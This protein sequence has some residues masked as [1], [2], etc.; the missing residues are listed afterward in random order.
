MGAVVGKGRFGNVHKAHDQETGESVALKF[1]ERHSKSRE[2][3]ERER[4]AF[5]LLPRHHPHI[6]QLRGVEEDVD[7]HGV[8]NT[9]FVLQLAKREDML[10][11]LLKNKGPLSENQSRTYFVQLL[12]ALKAAHARRLFHMDVKL[13][14][15]LLDDNKDILLCDWGLSLHL[16]EAVSSPSSDATSPS[17]SSS[18][19]PS[20]RCTSSDAH[21]DLRIGTEGYM[22]P[23]MFKNETY[24]PSKAD[25]WSAV[26]VV[27]AMYVGR[28]PFVKA[29]ESDWHFKRISIGSQSKFW[30]SHLSHSPWVSEAFQK[31][32]N[33]VFTPSGSTRA[34][35]DDI[36]NDPW[37]LASEAEPALAPAPAA[38]AD[39][40]R[41]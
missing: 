4:A 40:K 30:G 28:P 32:V 13:D 19:G 36:L 3:V 41:V 20:P 26:C 14:N 5:D 21:V 9:V 34:S 38:A 12:S 15:I 10:S 2:F 7:V 8:R 6:V 39:S 25:L 1:V 37:V 27:F 29:C 31:M 22:T 23:E 35:V 17:S 11:Y 16:P 24:S 18:C 33:R